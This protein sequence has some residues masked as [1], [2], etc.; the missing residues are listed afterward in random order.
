MAV[1]VDGGHHLEVG[2][3]DADVLRANAVVVAER[4]DRVLLLRFT[5]GHLRHDQAAVAGQ[6][7][8]VL[9]H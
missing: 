1:E 7:R 3:W 4:H 6:L 2:Q 8:L 9:L 5:T